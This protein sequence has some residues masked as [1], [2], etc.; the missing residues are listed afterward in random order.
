M[1]PAVS[2]PGCGM[3][4][5]MSAAVGRDLKGQDDVGV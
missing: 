4:V 5:A 1:N 2:M 3:W